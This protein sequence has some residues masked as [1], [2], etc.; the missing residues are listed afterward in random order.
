MRIDGTKYEIIDR[1]P[2]NAVNVR[3]YANNNNMAVGHVYVKYERFIT[4][5]SS[6]KPNYTIRCFQGMNFVIPE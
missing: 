5:K 4:G 2:S 1:L 3:Q 6:N